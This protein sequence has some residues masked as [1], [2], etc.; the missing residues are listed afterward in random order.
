MNEIPQS[1]HGKPLIHAWTYCATDGAPF[2]VVGRYQ[3]GSGKKEIVPFFK[4]NGATWA[5]GITLNPRP[6]FGLD[7]L[8][9][10]PR[11]KAV[12][13]VEGEKSA[14]ALQSIGITAV[15]SLGGSQ[16]ANQADWTP[17]NGYKLAYLLPDADEPGEHY[18]QDVY[19]ALMALDSPPQCKVV[20]L[21]GLPVKGDVVDWLQS[22]INDWD[23]YAPIAEN[24]HEALRE[25]LRAELKTAEYVPSDWTLAGLA[26]S[27]SSVFDWE[28]PGEIET[29]TPPVQAL[30]PEL[31]PEPFR[32]WLAD[33]SH[34]M[35]TPP[36]FAA[37][38]SIV[39]VGSIIGA[40]CSIKPKKLDDWEII[41]N[42]W[43][44]AIGRPS[45][46]LKSPSMKEPM[47]LL[48]R[49]QAE[50]GEQYEQDKAGAEFDMLANK[51]MIDDVK[52]Q[53]SKAA[54]GKGKDGVVKGDDL[55]KLKADYMELSGNAEP[56]PTRRL[57]KTNET[58]IQSMTVL[59]NQNPRG[60]LTFRDELTALLVKWDREDGADERAYFLEG[61]NGNGSYTDFKI[62]RGLTEAPN[63]CISLLGGIQ[64][65]KLRRYLY[66]AQNGSND[67]LMQRLQLAV[68]PDEPEHWRLIDTIPNKAEKRRAF[69][70]MKALAKLDF[71]GCGAVQSEYDD[72][73]YFR[74]DEAGQA[75]FNEWL[76]NLQTV[77]IQ[78]ETNPLMIEH[79]GKF[80][81]LMP[82]LA[83]IFHSIDIADGKARGNVSAQAARLAVEW[84][85]YLESHARRIYAMAESPEHEAAVRLADKIK[86]GIVPSPFTTKAIY[87]KGWHGLKDK[88]EVEAACNILIE[89]NWLMMQR[90]PKPPTGRPPLPEYYINPVFL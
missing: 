66:Q 72:R 18:M 41:P 74:F 26:G 24:L 4:R 19:R 20:V 29:K 88:E 38:S 63:V 82:S 49:L 43:G 7:K 47:S 51:A 39:I 2:G 31:I 10:H 27:C 80:R 28:K 57:F 89:E 79:F 73:P 50:Y 55:Q 86:A 52:V 83:L 85:G 78:Q 45:V 58:S 54:K 13:V 1:Y 30:P 16:A 53:L 33:V 9:T 56:E 40:G 60:L 36:D 75:V 62:G 6:L 25:E 61:W 70:I 12:F 17:L 76:T 32:H 87:D 44:A 14:A 35:Q 77:K 37:I 59:Q 67:G 8:A 15:S 5:A 81:S 69:D 68:W 65:D 21:S 90:K 46:V 22:F 42:V 34:R 23:G 11:D 71:I 3:D 48:E 84:C 64:P